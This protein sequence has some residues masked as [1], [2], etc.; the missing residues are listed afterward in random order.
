[1]VVHIFAN[2]QALT[3]LACYSVGLLNWSVGMETG[4]NNNC[5]AVNDMYTYCGMLQHN[6]LLGMEMT[7]FDVI[8][9]KW[10]VIKRL[11]YINSV[12]SIGMGD[13]NI[14]LHDYCH[15]Q[16]LWLSWWTIA[17]FTVVYELSIK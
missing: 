3:W 5:S 4:T 16:M 8:I 1:L 13:T 7:K 17:H 14:L 10:L 15:E 2:G 6:L 11:C 12:C 9:G